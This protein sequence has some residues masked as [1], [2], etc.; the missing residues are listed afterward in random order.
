MGNFAT[1]HCHLLLNL[2]MSIKIQSQVLPNDGFSYANFDDQQ[3]NI[4]KTTIIWLPKKKKK[5]TIIGKKRNT[6]RREAA[7]RHMYDV[8]M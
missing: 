7:R 5:T 4:L 6:R 1:N 3:S 8:P 2:F